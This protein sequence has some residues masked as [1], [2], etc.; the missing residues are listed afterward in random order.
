M[1]NFICRRHFS[2]LSVHVHVTSFQIW[3]NFRTSCCTSI[4][5][6]LS[7]LLRRWSLIYVATSSVTDCNE[8]E[9]LRS[10]FTENAFTLQ[11]VNA[12]VQSQMSPEHSNLPCEWRS[13]SATYLIHMFPSL[14][15][16]PTTGRAGTFDSLAEQL[17]LWAY[18][19]SW[20]LKPCSF[21]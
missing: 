2:L 12:E 10:E 6:V 13:T 19:D 5:A 16:S 18:Q 11:R 7:V 8:M 4:A 21:I 20:K 17:L 15:I 1:Y 9:S 14:R 3:S